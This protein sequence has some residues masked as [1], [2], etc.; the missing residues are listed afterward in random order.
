MNAAALHAWRIGYLQMLT[1]NDLAR[2][3]EHVADPSGLIDIYSLLLQRS[4]MADRRLGKAGDSK[5]I[6][7]EFLECDDDKALREMLMVSIESEQVGRMRRAEAAMA[8]F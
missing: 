6:I 2:V 1:D 7:N 8:T 4:P 3:A 5:W